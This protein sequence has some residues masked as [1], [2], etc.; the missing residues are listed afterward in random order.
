M[1]TYRIY[2]VANFEIEIQAESD[3]EARLKADNL[4]KTGPDWPPGDT[5]R[6]CWNTIDRLPGADD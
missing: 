5:L 1:T 2:F 4:V 6:C 3:M